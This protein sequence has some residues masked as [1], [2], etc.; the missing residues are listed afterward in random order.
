MKL[1]E[2][3]YSFGNDELAKTKTKLL[4]AFLLFFVFNLSIFA[5]VRYSNGNYIGAMLDVAGLL[6]VTGLYYLLKS[7]A[8]YYTF[9]SRAMLSVSVIVIFTTTYFEQAY[10]RG[11][12]W[13]LSLIIVSFYLRDRREGLLWA[14]LIAAIV[15]VNYFLVMKQIVL[16]EF[17]SF[18]FSILIISMIIYSYEHL[19]E[20]AQKIRIKQEEQEFLQTVIN[21]TDDPIMVIDKDYNVSLRNVAVNKYLDWDFIADKE[22]IK[23]YE[24]SHQRSTPCDT[25]EHP[26]PLRDVLETQN[27]ANA[28]HIH[29]DSEGKDCYVELSASPHRNKNGELI[30]IIEIARDITERIKIQEQ[31]AVEQVKLTYLTNHDPL[32]NLPNRFLFHD[33]VHQAI[34]R[35]HRSFTQF[36]VFFID[37]D[38]FKEVNDSLGHVVGDRVL[39]EATRRLKGHMREADTIARLGGDEFAL[40]VESAQHLKDVEY[41]AE[42]LLEL[43][44][45]PMMIDEHELYVSCSIGISLFPN[46]G[47]TPEALFRNADAAVYRAKDEGKNNYC[48]YTAE[49][50]ERAFERV[51]MESSLRRA[52]EHDEFRI[53]YQPQFDAAREKLIGMEAL[54]RWQHPELGLVT[55]DRFITQ[56]EE[57]G[58]I[59][60]IDQ[61]V[62]LHACRQ[63][64]FWNKKGL[65]PGN[66]AL[67]LSMKQ[68]HETDFIERIEHLFNQSGC[69]PENLE[70]EITESQIMHNPDQVIRVL[71]RVNALGISVAVDDFGTGYSSLAYLKRLPVTKLKIDQSFIRDLPDDEEDAGI[72]KAIIALAKSLKLTVIAEGVETEAQKNFLLHEGCHNIQGYFYGK[73]MPAEQYE[74]FLNDQR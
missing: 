40:I 6:V 25:D 46:D 47:E 51:L 48:F 64:A 53:F 56:A 55:P 27:H 22:H 50:T 59:I 20:K 67:N 58:L 69:H 2:T 30:G 49:M 34:K 12:A 5:I 57:S 74:V 36:V 62:M 14:M 4:I 13:S 41:V 68:L 28:L 9:I 54:I 52:I 18:F 63:V 66:L 8:G 37:L 29:K 70:L 65:K 61:W 26:C 39:K 31:L 42:R 1:F 10:S 32:T 71:N 7:S 44:R 35:A 45:K 11:V 43:F 16:F 24:I 72:T 73:P 33:R 60:Q 15:S 3:A 17:L 23:C 21:S 19:K 38:R